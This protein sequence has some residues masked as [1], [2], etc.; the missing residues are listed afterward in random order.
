MGALVLPLSV[1]AD[2]TAAP[3]AGTDAM[4]A[5][6]AASDAQ[7]APTT[8]G[9]M[10]LFNQLQTQ[11]AT[12]DQLEGRIEELQH[13]LDDQQQRGVQRY[14]ALEQRLSTLE[15]AAVS[16]SSG[17]DDARVEKQPASGVESPN[18]EA[19]TDYQKAFDLVQAHENDKAIAAFD[20]FSKQ[21]PDAP[22]RANA[23]YWLGELYLKRSEL[24][25]SEKAFL[26]VVDGYAKSSKRAD[27]LYKLGLV[28]ARQ[29]DVNDAQK[30]LQ[31]AIKEYPD[32]S[33]AGLAEKFLKKVGS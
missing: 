8:S 1:W 3:T 32:S 10:V 23:Q 12:I 2:E 4:V 18:G 15:A 5:S 6:S 29:G 24:D 22:L 13:Q 31:Q 26:A 16:T 7:N 28:K 9:S 21:Y 19:Q 11:Q 25:Q 20:A 17:N 33:A 30:R 27:A 14:E